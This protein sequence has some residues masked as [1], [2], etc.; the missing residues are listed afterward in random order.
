MKFWLWLILLGAGGAA[1]Y[2]ILSDGSSSQKAP[3]EP[4]KSE[5]TEELQQDRE[6]PTQPSLEGN[7]STELIL[8]LEGGPKSARKD[9]LPPTNR[10]SALHPEDDGNLQAG[11]KKDRDD[12]DDLDVERELLMDS[13]RD[14][15]RPVR[16]L[17]NR[18]PE[19]A[20]SV[21]SAS[22]S[23][24][25]ALNTSPSTASSAS[26]SS[27]SASSASTSS[28]AG[29]ISGA[30]LG[31]SFPALPTPAS[32]ST[33]SAP[34][35]SSRTF[36]SPTSSS[37]PSGN[38]AGNSKTS[39]GK[40][41][42]SS[43]IPAPN[44][45]ATNVAAKEIHTD[46]PTDELI[47]PLNMNES[48]RGPNDS[49]GAGGANVSWTEAMNI[50]NGFSGLMLTPKTLTAAAPPSTLDPNSPALTQMMFGV[51]WKSALDAAEKPSVQILK[52]CPPDP[53]NGECTPQPVPTAGP[54]PVVS[55]YLYQGVP[56]Q[57]DQVPDTKDILEIGCVVVGT[58]KDAVGKD[59]AQAECAFHIAPGTI[60]GKY[61]I[62]LN[63]KTS[64]L[65]GTFEV[66]AASGPNQNP[67]VEPAS[68]N[69]AIFKGQTQNKL[70]EPH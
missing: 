4:A 35:S 52:E 66:I 6:D 65:L 50:P 39:T 45:G 9:T 33:S 34:S 37:G 1:T 28:S 64:K 40:P 61:Q 19:A 14:L 11:A 17:K 47:K 51:T 42:N 58:Q 67:T 49:D 38:N 48:Q 46:K 20:T 25:V 15:P 70:P 21:P 23:T 62:L 3:A 30:S 5:I 16:R 12:D 29:G 43:T 36:S 27:G 10:L 32:S 55:D 26:S 69:R 24:P 8:P 57:E 59:V 22:P 18:T 54:G 2:L 13:A 31:G 68:L 63:G 53:A 60:P 41:T 7:P 44:D 56:H